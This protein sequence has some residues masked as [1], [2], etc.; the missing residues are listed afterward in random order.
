[1][2]VSAA[3]AGVARMASASSAKINKNVLQHVRQ[4]ISFSPQKLGLRS[5]ACGWIP[6]SWKTVHR[7][8]PLRA[9]RIPQSSETG[10]RNS[11]GMGTAGCL[12]A[13]PC[14]GR[15]SDTERGRASTHMW[16]TPRSEWRLTALQ[17][18]FGRWLVELANNARL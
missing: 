7:R 13:K 16:R 8:A 15:R 14:C 10:L 3:N 6:V 17:T 5:F 18:D 2:Q 1:M 4:L 12:R 9:L 11:M